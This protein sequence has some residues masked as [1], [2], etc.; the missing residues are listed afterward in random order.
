[1]TLMRKCLRDYCQT[2]HNPEY[3]AFDT[4]HSDS[5]N[6]FS[7]ND[8]IKK[9]NLS[10]ENQ[11][12]Q[13][14]YQSN[15][16]PQFTGQ[17]NSNTI[18]NQGFSQRLYQMSV[19]DNSNSNL[20]SNASINSTAF[21]KMILPT[22]PFLVQTEAIKKKSINERDETKRTTPK[23]IQNNE[24]TSLP[25]RFNNNLCEETSSSSAVSTTS[26]SGVGL[27]S[28]QHHNTSTSNLITSQLNTFETKKISLATIDN[29]QTYV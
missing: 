3:L 26:S 1:M 5:N 23:T 22:N 20:N 28:T 25:N 11:S 27:K 18:L 17:L 12:N 13:Q 9:N 16:L 15:T 4:I 29:K 14:L 19:D 6:H 10:N 8:Y 24:D 21:H 2:V 7:F